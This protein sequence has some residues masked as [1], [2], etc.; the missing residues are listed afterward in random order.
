MCQKDVEAQ[1]VTILKSIR[2][3]RSEVNKAEIFLLS[4]T[5]NNY[6]VF[7]CFDMIYKKT[8]IFAL[9][10]LQPVLVSAKE[11]LV[12]VSKSFYV[13]S[14]HMRST[15]RCQHKFLVSIVR[16]EVYCKGW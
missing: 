10:S 3:N 9:L 7:S 12:Q 14:I 1:V 8:T 11:C 6:L 2:G 5:T 4:S 13:R 16:G 15:D